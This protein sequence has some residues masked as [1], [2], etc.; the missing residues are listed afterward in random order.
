MGIKYLVVFVLILFVL[1]WYGESR[2]FYVLAKNKPIT[3]WK[4]YG[5]KCF[6]VFGKYYGLCPPEKDYIKTTNSN[7]LTIIVDDRSDIDFVVSNDYNA[8]V[9]IDSS[10]VQVKYFEYCKR[11]LFEEQYYSNKMINPGLNY[12]MIDIKENLIII[13]GQIIE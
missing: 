10:T 13:D 5:N 4:T 11:N 6:I 2:S 3:I 8:I 9:F 1:T 7:A 12:L